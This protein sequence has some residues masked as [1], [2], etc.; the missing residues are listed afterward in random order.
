MTISNSAKSFASDNRY[1]RCGAVGIAGG[2]GRDERLARGQNDI[3]CRS[4]AVRGYDGRRIGRQLVRHDRLEVRAHRRSDGI[5]DPVGRAETSADDDL[6]AQVGQG[7]IR[8]AVAAEVHA[9]QRKQRRIL[10]DRQQLP[11]AERIASRSEI[12]RECDDLPERRNIFRRAAAIS[13]RIKPVQGDDV[14]QRQRR[15][16][17]VD[18]NDRV[19]PVGRLAVQQ[20]NRGRANFGA[21]RVAR[22]DAHD[23][24]P[25]RIRHGEG[26]LAVAAIGRADE[27]KQRIVF[28]YRQ[29]AAVAE[30]EISSGREIAGEGCDDA[31]QVEHLAAAPLT[32][33]DALGA[34]HVGDRQG[35]LVI[36]ERRANPPMFGGSSVLVRTV[37]AVPS[38]PPIKAS[39]RPGPCPVPIIVV[40]ARS[41]GEIRP[42]VAAE[43]DAEQRKQRRVLS[44]RNQLSLAARSARRCE[45]EGVGVDFGVERVGENAVV[46]RVDVVAGDDRLSL[47]QEK[48]D[49]WKRRSSVAPF[50]RRHG[51]N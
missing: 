30:N 22:T 38:E 41:A 43:I 8:P 16:L 6:S 34:D 37:E 12:A 25:A 4:A 44:D 13:R 7:E 21:E 51:H 39:G 49:N 35:G 20:R 31:H 32:G 18:R 2:H 33:V 46:R 14:V 15:L 17:I 40:P 42:A 24:P 5:V 28:R 1:R 19:G 47:A 50:L 3:R 29:Q 26:R 27:A 11:V 23:R 10:A 9:E 36:V 48:I 45:I